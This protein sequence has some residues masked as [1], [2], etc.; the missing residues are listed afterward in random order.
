MLVTDLS[1]LEEVPLGRSNDLTKQD[2]K[3]FKAIK[4]VKP[5]TQRA[6]RDAYWLCQCQCGN[7]FVT[8]SNAISTKTC[9]SCGCLQKKIAVKSLSDYQQSIKGK[10]KKNYTHYK[11]GKLTVIGFSHIDKN[12]HSIWKCKCECGNI[13]FISSSDLA[14]KDIKSCGCLKQSY[15]SYKIEK[16]LQ[17]NNI[18]YVKEKTF[19][20]CRF[21]ETNALARFDFFINN[22]LV[23]FDGKQ[24]YE[25]V[26][27]F[28]SLDDFHNLQKRDEFKNQWCKENN[29]QLIRI[30]YYDEEQITFDYLKEKGV[31]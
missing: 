17:E 7:Y 2:F 19:D 31:I 3:G 1:S 22:K 16:I 9:Q 27:G 24:H 25:Y 8:S 10:P 11:C 30:P 18:P 12:R 23:E 14:K 26:G 29:I 15:G 20:S 4:R 6:G 28:F 21:P 13:T 5:L